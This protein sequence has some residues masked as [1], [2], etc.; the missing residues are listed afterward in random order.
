MQVVHSGNGKNFPLQTEDTL[1]EMTV[2]CVSESGA[3]CGCGSGLCRPNEKRR[4]TWMPSKALDIFVEFWQHTFKKT[5]SNR[6][7][8]GEWC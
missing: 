4:E 3:A 5:N 1:L 8:H 2:A 6:A 7:P